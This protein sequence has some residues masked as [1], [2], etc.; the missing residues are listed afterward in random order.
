MR[1]LL[2]SVH[3]SSCITW[4]S[5]LLFSY[6]SIHS[7]MSLGGDLWW[8]L[9]P[10]FFSV[11]KSS[12]LRSNGVPPPKG[13]E[14]Q[15]VQNYSSIK[16]LVTIQ[17]EEMVVPMRTTLITEDDEN[18]RRCK[19]DTHWNTPVKQSRPGLILMLLLS[20]PLQFR[21]CL[22]D[23]LTQSWNYRWLVGE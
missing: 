8:W 7:D 5:F 12:T 18:L 3:F 10:V 13:D 4:W 22:L 17:R 19:G 1:P 16:K 14:Y 21:N 6:D 11:K 23:G 15:S 9:T 20:D 2:H